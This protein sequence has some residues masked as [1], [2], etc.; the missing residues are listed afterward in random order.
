MGRYNGRH[1]KGYTKRILRPLKH[2]EAEERNANTPIER[3]KAHRKVSETSEE[4][5]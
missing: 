1:G 4:E 5:V 2:D 3:T